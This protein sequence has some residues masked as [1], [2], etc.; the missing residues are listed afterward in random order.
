MSVR[1]LRLSDEVND[2][3]KKRVQASAH[4]SVDAFLHSV[5][6]PQSSE[7][8]EAGSSSSGAN[9]EEVPQKRRKK[10]VREPLFSLEI[11][12]ERHEMLEY[13]TGMKLAAVKLVVKRL[14]EVRVSSFFLSFF[15]P[16]SSFLVFA[17][18]SSLPTHMS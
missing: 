8:E 10:N 14:R 16:S 6:F 12:A 3:L 11:L 2:E 5:L 18:F 7:S 9:E 13:Y 4:K 15:F 1:S 17:S